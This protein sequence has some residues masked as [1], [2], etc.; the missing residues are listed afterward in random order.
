M[1][2]ASAKP[3]MQWICNLGIESVEAD[4]SSVASDI[5]DYVVAVTLDIT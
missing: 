2:A 1:N 3:E 5:L 4:V